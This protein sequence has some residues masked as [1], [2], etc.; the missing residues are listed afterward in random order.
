ME[1]RDNDAD[2][3]KIILG[4][5]RELGNTSTPTVIYSKSKTLRNH[6]LPSAHHIHILIIT[7][8]LQVQFLILDANL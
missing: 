2:L 4:F 1:L 6:H 7:H 8:I 3:H 5:L